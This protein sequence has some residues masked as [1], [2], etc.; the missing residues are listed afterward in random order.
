[1][2]S[3]IVFVLCSSL[4]GGEFT[5]ERNYFSC[6]ATE[7]VCVCADVHALIR[8]GR[9]RFHCGGKT[10]M[11]LF[12]TFVGLNP[13]S[14]RRCR[15]VHEGGWSM[16]NR[17]RRRGLAASPS[18]GP[19]APPPGPAGPPPGPVAPGRWTQNLWSRGGRGEPF[20][21]WGKPFIRAILLCW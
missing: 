3:F 21:R 5:Q 13:Y 1:M 14:L 20:S 15:F 10:G 16:L 2:E 17:H 19:A 9:I 18:P 12:V 11:S 8:F 6:L 4:H 7:E